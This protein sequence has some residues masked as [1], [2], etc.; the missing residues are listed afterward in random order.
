IK[1]DVALDVRLEQLIPTDEDKTQLMALFAE[2]E[3][4][5]WVKELQAQGIETVPQSAGL[6]PSGAA[7]DINATN[8]SNWQTTEQ[9]YSLVNTETELKT[10]INA[11]R[12]KGAFSVA[13]LDSGEH[14]MIARIIGLSFSWQPGQAVY[15]PL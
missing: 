8:E 12:G 4:R 3:F 11:I 13:V 5:S 9:D 7:G 10:C 2:F 14:F 6:E 1:L 15:L